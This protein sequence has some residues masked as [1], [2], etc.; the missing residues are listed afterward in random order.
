MQGLTPTFKT[1]KALQISSTRP[2]PSLAR[3]WAAA[4]GAGQAGAWDRGLK[5]G[6]YVGMGVNFVIETER[7][8]GKEKGRK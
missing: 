6:A 1:C 7:E 2:G 8:G 5:G 3:A 4:A